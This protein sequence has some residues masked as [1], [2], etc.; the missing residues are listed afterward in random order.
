[1]IKQMKLKKGKK[2]KSFKKKFKQMKIKFKINKVYKIQIIIFQLKAQLQK[3][4]SN[5]MI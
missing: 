4:Q 5:K 1:M 3:V 2:I